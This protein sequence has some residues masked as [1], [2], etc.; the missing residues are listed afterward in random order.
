M[1]NTDDKNSPSKI[2]HPKSHRTVD[3]ITQIIEEVVY[4]PGLSFKELVSA[5]RAPKSTIHGFIQGLLARGWLY[6][7]GSKFYLGPAAY[8]LTLAGG[9]IKASM[10]TEDDLKELSWKT[11]AAVYMGILAGDHLIYVA[12]AGS[13]HVEGFAAR[14]NIRRCLLKTAGG[15]ALLADKSA[16]ERIAYLRRQEQ[17]PQLVEQFLNEL[18]TIQDSRI[19]TN[20]LDT[21]F[22]LAT[23]LHNAVGEAVA[24]I[25]IVGPASKLENRTN[26]LSE[27]LLQVTDSWS[28]RPP[29]G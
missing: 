26:E 3:R 27:V 18:E 23:T 21:R 12:E 25:T 6:E 7:E 5:L 20:R 4:R 28:H 15:K 11:G 19:A 22:A 17:D 29:K 13:D 9:Q 16:S 1:S 10:I 24:S 14:T 2:H 8:G